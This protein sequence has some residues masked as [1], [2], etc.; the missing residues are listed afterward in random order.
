MEP[1]IGI[2]NMAPI[3]GDATPQADVSWTSG[4]S[5]EDGVR[6]EVG[7]DI[8]AS[9]ETVPVVQGEVTVTISAD[10]LE[11][12]LREWMISSIHGSPI[13]QSTP[14][15]NHLVAALPALQAIIM[16]GP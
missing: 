11:N 6:V 8:A 2:Y 16:R 15:Y 13:S 5:V 14:A 4:E 1:Q 3:E 9:S 7:I 12:K 10:I